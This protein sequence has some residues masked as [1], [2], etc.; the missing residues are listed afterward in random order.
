[1]RHRDGF[2]Y[3]LDQVARLHEVVGIFVRNVCERVMQLVRPAKVCERNHAWQKRDP[4]P[5]II[6]GTSC[7]QM[8]VDTLMRHHC[9]DEDQVSS[10]QHVDNKSCNS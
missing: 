5:P 3:K 2:Q 9:A 1:M 8:S 4:S 10:Q 7:R 6:S